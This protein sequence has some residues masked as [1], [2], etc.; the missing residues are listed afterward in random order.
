MGFEVVT[1]STGQ[2]GVV[3]FTERP[4]AF[5]VVL[6]DLTMPGMRGDVTYR[7]LRGMRPDLP[8][9]VMSG[10]SHQEASAYFD[11]QIL[12]GFLQKPF[13]LERLRDVVRDAL[14]ERPAPAALATARGAASTK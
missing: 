13:K 5:A 14:G 12:A 10:Y 4:A 3:R 6:L 11:A 1:A 9:I 7:H 2:E 8:I